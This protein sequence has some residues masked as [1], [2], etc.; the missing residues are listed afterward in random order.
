MFDNEFRKSYPFLT[1]YFESIL[2]S[3]NKTLSHCILF[4]GQNIEVQYKLAV[5]IARILNCKGNKSIDCDCFSC[6]WIRENK[7]PSVVTVSPIDFKEDSSK[8]VISV[9]Q[10]QNI[11]ASL[12]NTSEYYRVFIICDAKIVNDEWKPYGLNFD[13][14]KAEASNAL[15]KTIEETPQNTVFFFLTRDKSDVLATISSRAQGFFVPNYERKNESISEVVNLFENYPNLSSQNLFEYSQ[16]FVNQLKVDENI[17]EKC[18]S[19]FNQMLKANL[20]NSLLKTKIIKDMFYIEK[21]KKMFDK[22]I[23]PQ[24][25]S[26]ELY[27]SIMGK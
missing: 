27:L 15:L 22:G 14:F 19:Y 18:L 3:E 16:K 24:T 2:T 5:E 4:Y 7:H 20:D 17:F 9:K 23:N 6:R 25:L 26:E 10:I 12:V 13:N 8:T 11:K 21:A 1:Q